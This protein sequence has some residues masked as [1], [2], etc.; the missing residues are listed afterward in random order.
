MLSNCRRNL[1]KVSLFLSSPRYSLYMF[2][3]F[4]IHLTSLHPRFRVSNPNPI[5]LTSRHHRPI[6]MTSRPPTF[7]ASN[8]NSYSFDVTP[9]SGPR[10]RTSNLG[11]FVFIFL[12]GVRP[13]VARKM[14]RMISII[15][16]ANVR[17]NMTGLNV[18][19]R[20][21]MKSAQIIDFTGIGPL[22][23]VLLQIRSE[24]SICI[25]ASMTE[26]LLSNGFCGT[27]YASVDPVMTSIHTSMCQFCVSHP[28]PQVRPL[29]R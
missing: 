12:R 17:R 8:P 10:T 23:P 15:G 19:S 9:S 27:V 11:C 29:P 7:T 24:S 14:A 2:R 16:D 4:S 21:V 25:F 6:L 28:D 26:P 18:A 22:E 20:E 1:R 13:L 5:R 3:L